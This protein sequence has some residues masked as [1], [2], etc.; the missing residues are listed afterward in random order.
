M[1]QS[2]PNMS[3]NLSRSKYD[4]ECRGRI[5]S[6]QIF[7]K[8]HYLFEHRNT[9][10]CT[11]LHIFSQCCRV[12]CLQI[13]SNPKSRCPGESRFTRGVFTSCGAHPL[14]RRESAAGV[15]GT[16]YMPALHPGV[17][18]ALA[19]FEQPLLLNVAKL[20][21]TSS[22]RDALHKSMV[23]TKNRPRRL[24]AAS[25]TSQLNLDPCD[26]RLCR[27]RFATLDLLS[28]SRNPYR[29]PASPRTPSKF[30]FRGTKSSC[31]PVC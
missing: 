15:R 23:C 28:P 22:L 5:P 4:C 14:W 18:S 27:T 25:H 10:D 31:L 8:P 21:V 2:L 17:G 11:S 29:S 9:T 1:R 30:H 19:L 6:T 26:L 13:N 16:N 3:H 24:L 7:I 12:N 20:N